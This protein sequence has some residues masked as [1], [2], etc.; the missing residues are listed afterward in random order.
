MAMFLEICLIFNDSEAVSYKYVTY[1]KKY[2]LFTKINF[3]M[4]RKI[5]PKQVPTKIDILEQ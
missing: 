3:F 2:A 4:L 1:L 5:R